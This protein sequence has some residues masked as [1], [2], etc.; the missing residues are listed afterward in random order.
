MWQGIWR[1]V[2][3]SILAMPE[4][5]D[6]LGLLR[7]TFTRHALISEVACL[8]K[9]ASSLRRLRSEAQQDSYNL[10]SLGEPQPAQQ[11]PALKLMEL[12]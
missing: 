2:S 11:H 8:R 9:P 1:F 6:D 3:T 5:Q 10:C 12:M 7:F 4:R